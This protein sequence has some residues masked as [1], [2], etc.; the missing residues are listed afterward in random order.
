[1]VST[2]N[3]LY[4]VILYQTRN[5][6][7]SIFSIFRGAKRFGIFRQIFADD[8][9]PRP[10]VNSYRVPVIIVFSRQ[11]GFIRASSGPYSAIPGFSRCPTY[12]GKADI[13]FVYIL[14]VAT[15]SFFSWLFPIITSE[16]GYCREYCYSC[17]ATAVESSKA[18]DQ[19]FFECKQT[20]PNDIFF[21]FL[22][23]NWK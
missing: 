5:S 7:Q 12:P 8:T 22:R 13:A 1:M 4:M 19:T 18:V 17:I 15:V 3:I 16:E 14:C 10:V 21:P 2:Y 11:W 9:D 23:K 20:Q 6:L